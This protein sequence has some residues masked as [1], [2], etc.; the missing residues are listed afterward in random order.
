MAHMSMY[1]PEEVPTTY[2]NGRTAGSVY[3][4]EKDMY[5]VTFKRH[6]VCSKCWCWQQV[7][8][9][10]EVLCAHFGPWTCPIKSI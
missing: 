8:M 7:E 3:F 2:S 5:A 4:S 10:L 9:V 6:G 1:S